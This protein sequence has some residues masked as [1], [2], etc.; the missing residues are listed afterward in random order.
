MSKITITPADT[1]Y[2]IRA[3]GAVLGES[4]NALVLQE[5]SLD[6]VIYFPREDVAMALLEPTAHKTHCPFKG[7]ASYFS[8][9]T[10]S[11]VI[12]NSVWSYENPLEAARDI[13]SYLAFAGENVA[14]ERL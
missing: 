14:V 12:E 4:E 1:T 9:H 10:K 5:G 11:T 2:V 8:I 6:P 7:E 13:A 3:G